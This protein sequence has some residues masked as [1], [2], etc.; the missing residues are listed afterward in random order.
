MAK[1]KTEEKK[2]Q[3]STRY[4][5]VLQQ[6][7]FEKNKELDIKNLNLALQEM[8]FPYYAL[9]LHDKFS[10]VELN[11]VEDKKKHFHIVIDF[12]ATIKQ[13]TALTR[14]ADKL[15][16]SPNIISI[17]PLTSVEAMVRYLIHRDQP[18]KYQF[19]SS[20]ILT[21]NVELT[22]EYLIDQKVIT[23]QYILN[24]ARSG[25]STYE[26]MENIGVKQFNAF[27]STISLLVNGAHREREIDKLRMK[28][29]KLVEILRENGIEV[30]EVLET[31][32]IEI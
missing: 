18:E 22:N 25:A 29:A 5:V 16:V 30:P 15:E 27:H 28:N 1:T 14:L 21:N 20:E 10:V 2:E 3:S 19:D 31:Q 32:K 6:Q 12:G 9:I 11:G 17:D 7:D 23:T 13:T 8:A 24:W 4:A 26:L